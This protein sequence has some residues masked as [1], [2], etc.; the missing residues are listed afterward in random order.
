MSIRDESSSGSSIVDILHT[1]GEKMGRKQQFHFPAEM[2]TSGLPPASVALG[3]QLLPI[4]SFLEILSQT[5]RLSL[6]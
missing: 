4:S 1:K 3:D 6:G 2:F 5:S